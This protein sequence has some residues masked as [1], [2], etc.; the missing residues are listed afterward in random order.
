M[1]T[2]RR[3]VGDQGEALAAAWYEAAGYRV[4]DRNWRCRDGEID[5]VC[6]TGGTIVICE[7]KTRRSSAFGSPAEAATP[8]KRRRLRLLAVRWLREHHVSCHDVRFDLA[9]VTGDRVEVIAGAW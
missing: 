3:Q 4:L 2:Y 7:V 6:R 8:A 9:A 5:L 1:T